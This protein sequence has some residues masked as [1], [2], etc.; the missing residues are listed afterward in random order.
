M[1]CYANHF[2]R[3]QNVIEI[4]S[5]RGEGSTRFFYDIC[6]KRQLNFHTVD[7]DPNIFQDAKSIAGDAAHLQ[8]G[9]E[10]LQS[11]Q[12]PISFAYLDNFDWDWGGMEAQ[13]SL[14]TQ[15][16]SELGQQLNNDNSQNAHLEQAQLIESKAD[17]P[18]L[19]LFDDT[20]LDSEFKIWMRFTYR[21]N[22]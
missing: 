10:F 4:G 12:G 21:T 15:R 1:K 13:I 14:Q 11:F 19:I 2:T 18:C 8:D 5:E 20:Y 16:Y 22:T 7:F 17:D 3:G 6:K 9:A